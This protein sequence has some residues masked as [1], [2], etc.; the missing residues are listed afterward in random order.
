[1][2]H[3]AGAAT[4]TPLPCGWSFQ[5]SICEPEIRI[6]W[7]H[8]YWTHC[9]GGLFPVQVPH[10]SGGSGLARTISSLSAFTQYWVGTGSLETVTLASWAMFARGVRSRSFTGVWTTIFIR[11]GFC[12]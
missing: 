9:C 1:M 7:S 4:P 2:R 8:V 12:V 6:G 11:G 5:K 10:M 3:L